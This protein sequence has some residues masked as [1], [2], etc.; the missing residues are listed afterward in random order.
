MQSLLP[1]RFLIISTD[2]EH[3]LGAELTR[4]GHHVEMA[5]G[6]EVTAAT[7]SLVDVL[8]VESSRVR[9]EAGWIGVLCNQARAAE[10]SLIGLTS[11]LEDYEEIGA[12]LTLGVD[13]YLVSPVSSGELRARLT[14]LERRRSLSLRRQM[15]EESARGEIERLAAIIQTQNDIALAGLDLDLVMRLISERA[16]VLCG[17]GGAAVGVIE[18][19]DMCYRVATGFSSQ[20]EGTRLPVSTTFAGSSILRGEV[21]RT[22]DTERD[23]RV[24]VHAARKLKVRSMITVPLKRDS[25]T[26]GVLNVVSQVP[27]A[28]VDSDERTLELMA[29]LLGA[30]MGN[31]AEHAA[32]QALM[33]EVASIVTSLQETQHLFDSFMNNSPALGYMKDE[34]GQHV[35]VNE[36]YRRFFGLGPNHDVSTTRD[37]QLMPPEVVSHVRQ[38]DQEAFESGLPT[39]SESVIPTPDGRQRHWLTYRFI[40]R[41]SSGQRFLGAVSF[42]ITERKAAEEALRLSEESF[43]SLIEASPEAIFVHRGGPLLF[44]NP[45]ACAFLRMPARELVGRSLL[46]FVHPADRATA[47]SMLD[48]LPGQDSPR[49]REVRFQIG[50]GSVLTAEISSLRL[51]FTGQPAT[52]VSARDLTERK[53]IQE[54]LVVADRLA[55]VGTLAAGVAHEINNPLAFIISNL[56]F[57]SEELHAISS[58]M[59]AGRMDE[60]QEV[61]DETKKGFDRVRD[62]VQ[63]LKTFSRGDDE[64]TSAVDLKRVVESALSLARGDLRTRATVVKELYDVPLV[65][66]SEAKLNQ[67]VL[68]LLINASQAITQ[69]P[70]DKNEIR[71]VLRTEGERA[72]I[73]VKDTGNGIPRDVL[74]RI[75]DPFFTTKP[76]GEGTGLGLSICH[77]IITSFG[78]E[79]TVHSEVGHGSTFRIS[80][81]ALKRMKVSA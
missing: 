41:D 13:D 14:L 44:V 6:S 4:M 71:V 37:E 62:I 15:H 7:V 40:A 50:E 29:G 80:L 56:S 26:V 76:V 72:I 11:T 10:V 17:A 18:G 65:E 36:P 30:A 33:T 63:K 51:V 34:L 3:P 78:G 5:S 61:L 52:L 2:A 8:V 70:P 35:W 39:V 49:V 54:R 32:K 81:P 28:F 79:I 77:G 21:M 20:F 24:N 25:Q 69:G 58:E 57:L 53:Q 27:Y 46:D 73:E 31:A 47:A 67:V 66:G 55:S 23:P 16:M 9:E 64:Q 19:E 59:P 68:N 38:Q 48:P 1:M 75:F 74:G 60:M 22:D 42:D 43:R 45:S 12:L